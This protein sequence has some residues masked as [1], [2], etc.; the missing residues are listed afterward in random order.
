MLEPVMRNMLV[1]EDNAEMRI[2]VE[3]ALDE[4]SLK[5]SSSLKDAKDSVSRERFDL[6]LLDVILPELDG[7][8]VL[9]QLKEK[10]NKTPVIVLS[11]LGQDEDRAKAKALGAI[12]YMVKSNAPLSDIVEVVK[13]S[14]AK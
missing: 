10:G 5:F 14:L 4:Y 8:S 9:A 2:L 11:N 7:F 1:V 13:H 3:A 6:I 12:D